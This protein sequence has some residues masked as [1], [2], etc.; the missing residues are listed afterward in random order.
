MLL[1]IANWKIEKAGTSNDDSVV[2]VRL[3]ANKLDVD[4]ENQEIIPA[5]FNKATVDSFL[6][7]GIIDWHHQSVIGKNPEDR[8]RAILGKPTG[9]KWEDGLPAV[10][11]NL[12]K[13][14]PI[15]RDSILPHLEAG[16]PVFGAS[17]GG[18]V[19][20]A[21]NVWDSDKSRLKEQIS[22]IKWDHLAIAARPYVISEGTEVS[23]VK[24]YGA[25]SEDIY[26][27]YSDIGTFGTQY[28]LIKKGSE[29]HK[30]LTVGAG[31]DSATL[32][33]VDALRIQSLEGND[34]L[35]NKLLLAL[36][37]NTI[38]AN[39]GGVEMFLRAEGLTTDQA[40]KETIRLTEALKNF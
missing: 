22:E 5:A 35:L 26:L 19:K 36:K 27:K 12:T 23:M 25:S 3:V 14:H 31:T 7:E 40:Q 24:A 18:N 1:E 38:E 16:Q 29:L 20:K 6:S 9:F 13:S 21:K 28:E 34:A 4:K 8:A 10:Y 2:P 15:V 30:A 11:A 33:G 17:V 32:T 39:R 37:D